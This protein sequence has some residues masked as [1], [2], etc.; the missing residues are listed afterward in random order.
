ML[1]ARVDASSGSLMALRQT[2]WRQGYCPVKMLARAG[3]HTGWFENAE[4]NSTPR[5]AMRSIFGVRPIGFAPMAPT[6]SARNWSE[7]MRTIFG[8][9]IWACGCACAADAITAA[10]MPASSSRREGF[11]DTRYLAAPAAF[12]G[13]EAAKGDRSGSAIRRASGPASPAA[14]SPANR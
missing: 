4:R 10:G 6:Q 11:M 14:Y 7:M 8:L 5:A 9:E 1:L 13:R 3:A 2:P 12:N